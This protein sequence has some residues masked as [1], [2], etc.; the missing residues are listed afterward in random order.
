MLCMSLTFPALPIAEAMVST[1]VRSTGTRV[2]LFAASGEMMPY[3]FAVCKKPRAFS[4][5]RTPALTLQ[6]RRP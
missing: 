2:S 5:S 6:H 1:S 4:G 3:S